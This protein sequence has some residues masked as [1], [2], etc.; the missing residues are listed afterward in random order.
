MSTYAKLLREFACFEDLSEDQ[1]KAIAKITDAICYP[2][3][4]DLVRE[5]EEGKYLYLLVKGELE[6]LHQSDQDVQVRVNNVSDQEIIGCSALVEP[7]KYAA[8][9]RSLTEIE[10]LQIDL[11]SLRDLM[12]N[13]CQLG[14]MINQ[15]I[16]EVL[17]KRIQ[18][19][20]LTARP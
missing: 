13:D 1:I 6:V 2:N 3:D 12:K 15:H 16:I 9:E 14:L 4:Y 10:V 8:T 19:F 18:Q 11:A 20:R 17:M 7:Y 5:G